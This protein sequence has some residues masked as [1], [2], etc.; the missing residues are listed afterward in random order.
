MCRNV[1]TTLATS[2]GGSFLIGSVLQVKM[3]LAEKI[4]N[5]QTSIAIGLHSEYQKQV[6][7]P[8]TAQRC[9][10]WYD[11]LAICTNSLNRL[12]RCCF[13]SFCGV[14]TNKLIFPDQVNWLY[15]FIFP[16]KAL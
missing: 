14:S 7:F 1:K 16:K 12:I 6:I 5:I 13:S 11:K 2:K 15:C 3:K 10:A 8:L 9:R 4:K